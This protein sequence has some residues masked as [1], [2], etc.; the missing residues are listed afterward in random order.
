MEKR[1]EFSR[2]VGE[3]LRGHRMPVDPGMWDALSEKLLSG[4]R[5]ISAY[6]VWAGMGP[7]AALLALVLL[8][9]PFAGER[10][11]EPL[12]T[13]E[14]ILPK[15][16]GQMPPVSEIAARDTDSRVDTKPT[17][18]H[19]DSVESE[20]V[21]RI[22]EI[23]ESTEPEGVVESAEPV[24]P[25]EM[26]VL[27]EALER[28]ESMDSVRTAERAEVLTAEALLAANDASHHVE[29]E[30]DPGSLMVAMGSGGGLSGFPFGEYYGGEP[31]YPDFFPGDGSGVGSEVGGGSQYNLLTPADYT[32][33]E[34]RPPLSFSVVAGFPINND[35][36]LET[37]LS[38]TYLF[39]RFRRND[40]FIYRG[41]L[42]QHYIGIPVNLRYRLWHNG[43]W[44]VYLL[45][46]GSIEKGLRAV[47]KQE[48]EHNGSVVHHTNVYNRINGF[49]FSAQGGAGF[50]YRWQSNLHLFA[51]PRLIYYFN[52]HQPMSV[53]T[54][55]PLVFG[56]NVGIRIQ[57]I[58]N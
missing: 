56:L 33:I 58:S 51:E 55:N 15:P 52:S 43:A 11:A 20:D 26:P 19:T 29:E 38:Y 25:L 36:S 2:I 35:L 4:K 24:E 49:Q 32:D 27:A 31:S 45:G 12:L 8:L 3:K 30:H 21:G 46:G 1:D 40:H 28:E 50:S 17:Q 57:F 44:H 22:M 39:S 23:T 53:R 54:E 16:T 48:I 42:Q 37:G 6:W 9:H 10:D 41:T 13:E 7:V 34:H 14:V 5:R 47:Y 18:Q